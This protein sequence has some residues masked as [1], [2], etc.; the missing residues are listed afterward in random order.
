MKKADK[1]FLSEK[2][3][4]RFAP[5]RTNG[6]SCSGTRNFKEIMLVTS[7]SFHADLPLRCLSVR[8]YILLPGHHI[9]LLRPNYL[10]LRLVLDGSEYIRYGN[11]VCLMEPGDMMIFY[12]MH[13]WEYMTGPD[14]FSHKISLCFS[15]PLLLPALEHSS[16]AERFHLQIQDPA[17]FLKIFRELASV[18]Q[19]E[20]TYAPAENAALS[21]KL[22]QMLSSHCGSFDLPSLL[23][24]LR[25]YIE[26][27]IGEE[28]T[29]EK[30]AAE[31]KCS[32]SS[33]GRLFRK[34]LNSSVHKYIVRRRMEEALEMLCFRNLSVKETAARLGFRSQF[35]FS[36]EFKKYHGAPPKEFR[37]TP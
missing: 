2:F 25:Q 21:L 27:H 15:G 13:D 19:S 16:L 34:N 23:R 17:P 4:D 1:N 37:R 14:R 12:P 6:Y 35:N 11:S 8:E 10:A 24:A 33:I 5:P 31:F 36:T 30:L 20:E 29:L 22:L 18:I 26:R 9:R 3:W 32:P 28:L 7:S